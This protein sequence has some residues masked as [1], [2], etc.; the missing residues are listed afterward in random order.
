[1]SDGD[2]FTG[3]FLTGAVVGGLVGAFVGRW[4][5]KQRSPEIEA[6]RNGNNGFIE[7]GEDDR[8]PSL[9]EERMEA[10]RQSLEDKIAQ[11]NAAIDEVR[12]SFPQE[13]DRS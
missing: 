7:S 11:L 13:G 5:A 12:D 6:A 3:G 1:M 9:E 10:V 2:G 4:L 8:V